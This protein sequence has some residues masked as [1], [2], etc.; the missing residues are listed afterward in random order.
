VFSSKPRAIPETVIIAK[1]RSA[2]VK[3]SDFM[4][5]F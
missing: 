1:A 5:R 4:I 2:P 3:S